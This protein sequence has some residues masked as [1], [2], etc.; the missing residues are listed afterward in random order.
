MN[1]ELLRAFVFTSSFIVPRSSFFLNG[2]CYYPSD[3]RDEGE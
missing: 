1:D 3:E 2:D